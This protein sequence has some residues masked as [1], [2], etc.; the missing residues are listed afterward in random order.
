MAA[1]TVDHF[2]PARATAEDRAGW[3]AIFGAGQS[4][5]SGGSVDIAE[6]AG[7]LIAVD[8]PGVLRWAARRPLGGELLAVAELRP[9]PQRAGLGFLRLF[10]TPPARRS[11]VGSALLRPVVR[12]AAAAGFDRIQ[13]T[14]LA[15]PPGEPFARAWPGLRIAMRLEIQEQRLD[16][17]TVL[18]RCRELAATAHPGYRL[19]HWRAAAPDLLAASFG[20]VMGHV[21]DAPGAMFQ[22]AAR[23]WAEPRVRAWEQEMTAGGRQLL[24]CAAVDLASGTAVAATVATVPA[25][26]GPTADQHDTAV[27]PT[28]RERGLARWIKAEQA[29]QLRQ[30]F[31]DV[32]AI[33]VTLNKQNHPMIAVN[34]T[35]G[36]R[37]VSDRLLVELPISQEAQ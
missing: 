27:L 7:R 35:L 8:D 12:G 9:Q 30:S 15:G 1:L 11:G 3:S 18:R 14:V 25:S 22:M 5:A 29:I 19:Q 21:L 17:P 34:R 20:Q 6:L 28:H 32:T 13:A 4:E 31:P 16:N 2:V 37:A 23:R 36:Y 26:G 10:V 33:V 24:V